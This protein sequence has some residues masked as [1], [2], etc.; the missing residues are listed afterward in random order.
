MKSFFKT[1]LMK[2][3]NK[4][5]MNDLIDL[6][7]DYTD[8]NGGHAFFIYHPQSRNLELKTLKI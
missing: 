5:K 4:T 6:Y 8:V 1:E 7:R 3:T 2:K